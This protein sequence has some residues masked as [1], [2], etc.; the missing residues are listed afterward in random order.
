[1]HLHQTEIGTVRNDSIHLTVVLQHLALT[2]KK[3]IQKTTDK[4]KR[5]QDMRKYGRNKHRRKKKP[6]NLTEADPIGDRLS[7]ASHLPSEYHSDK[8][9]EYHSPPETVIETA[10]G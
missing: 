8:S 4:G 10:E 6:K 9:E 3:P 1:M 7:N 5:K 2:V